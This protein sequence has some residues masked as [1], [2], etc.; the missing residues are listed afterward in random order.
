MTL[1]PAS[2]RC[3][4]ATRSEKDR[5]TRWIDFAFG[6][7]FKPLTASL[8]A[9]RRVRQIGEAT[10]RT[11]A[12]A[13]AVY[14]VLIGNRR[15]LLSV[16]T[17]LCHTRQAISGGTGPIPTAPRW[18]ALKRDPQNSAIALKHPEGERSRIS[19]LSINVTNSPNSGI[20]FVTLSR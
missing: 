7:F 4:E 18:T 6:W 11:S 2:R 9:L 17:A 8:P 1:S 3:Y 20:V 10:L 5:L 14:A 13:L 12:V 16:P 19:C 15:R